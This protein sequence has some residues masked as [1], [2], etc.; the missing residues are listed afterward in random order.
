MQRDPTESR[1]SDRIR[2]EHMR[3]AS[4]AVMQ[5]IDGRQRSDLESDDMLR[6]A[7]LHAIQEIGEAA[8]RMS[9]DGRALAPELP[10]GSIVQMRHIMV[11][12]YWG[13]DLDRVW[14]VAV[15]NMKSIC[16]AAERAIPRLP[17]HDSGSEG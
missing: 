12:V 7:V 8:A 13:V 4:S 16:E 9:E 10:W 14:S 17:L 5:F 1:L 3:Q 11:H 6:R 15:N 2:Y